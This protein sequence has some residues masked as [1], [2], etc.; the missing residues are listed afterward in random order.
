MNR[1]ICM[2]LSLFLTAL[3]YAAPVDIDCCI[4]ASE[5]DGRIVNAIDQGNLT[6]EIEGV[7]RI[8]RQA[9][10]SFRLRRCVVTNDE[11]L[12]TINSDDQDQQTPLFMAMQAD[13]ALNLFFVKRV[14]GA[15][16][17]QTEFGI[18]MG[19]N[20]GAESIAHEIGHACGLRDIYDEHTETELSLDGP[21]SRERM[22]DDWGRY[23]RGTNQRDVI[24]RMLMYGYTARDGCDISYG[25]VFGLWYTTEEQPGTNDVRKVWHL[26]L[27]PVGF[28]THGNRHPQSQ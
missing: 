9:A 24:K 20:C 12:A 5:E 14:V 2:S 7:N 27:A 18:V 10:M 4:V 17:F 22:P 1:C 11:A 26:S 3:A 16:A 6:N 25:D 21:P 28:H 13:G 15:V 23:R 19:S 8:F